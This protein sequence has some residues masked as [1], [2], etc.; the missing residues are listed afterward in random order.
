MK[1]AG[2]AGV[3]LTIVLVAA[4]ERVLAPF[5]A[6]RPVLEAMQDQLPPALGSSLNSPN[7]ATWN[8]WS[9]RQDRE[10]RARLVQGEVDSMINLLLFGTSFTRRPRIQ[11]E[12]LG[13]ATRSGLL[14]SRVD[15]L[16]QG[17]RLPRNN[18]RL[19]FLRSLFRRQGLDPDSDDGKTGLFVYQ[20]L[21]RVLRENLEFAKRTEPGSR[22]PEATF[23]DRGV[24][25]DATILPNF[26]IEQAL[27][28]LKKGGLLGEGDVARVA[29]IG[30]GLDFTDKQSGYDYY[31][32]QTLQPFAVYD[33]L[34]RLGL[35]KTGGVKITVFDI[36]S[37]VLEHMRRA[38]DA[39]QKG[40][41]YTIQL[42]RESGQ[43]GQAWTPEAIEYWRAFGDR[44]GKTVAPIRPPAIVAGLESRA[45]EIRPAVVLSCEPVDLNIVLERAKEA[46]RFDL[47]VATNVFV[48]YGLLEQAL[49]FQ[50][51]STLLKPG[52]ILLSNDALPEIP[53]VPMRRAGVTA[54]R[55]TGRLGTT[56]IWYRRQ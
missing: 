48:Y 32:Q 56:V 34:E 8:A 18:E 26:G 16:V 45:V 42:P 43:P 36:S 54:A 20:N 21:Q 46:G 28:E 2:I 50:N 24:S 33:S 30:P 53:T 23:R 40:R 4:A 47:I 10:I 17:V 5:S 27:G 49:A 6:V 12:S 39:A 7:E 51:V 44:T 25:L 15:D 1:I 19:V 3:C 31:P 29:V 35:A 55:Y 41:G 13:E 11:F 38:R 22:D 52:G 9:R 14:R 37:R